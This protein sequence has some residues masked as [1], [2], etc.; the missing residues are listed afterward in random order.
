MA[1]TIPEP[2]GTCAGFVRAG[3]REFFVRVGGAGGGL[4][5]DGDLA[6]LLGEGG[7]A[8]LEARLPG[9]G[10]D[11]QVAEV[12]AAARAAAAASPAAVAPPPPPAFYA[13]LLREVGLCGW[14]AVGAVAPD[15]SGVTLRGGCGG[16]WAVEAEVLL[17]SSFPSDPPL[18]VT[19]DLPEP[20]TLPP[21]PPGGA[22]GLSGVLATLRSAARKW[23]AH[24]AALDCLDARCHVLEPER[25][26]RAHLHRRVALR[27]GAA[28]RVAL[29]K[30]DAG[31][32]P[33][34]RVT[35]PEKAARGPREA[36]SARLSAWDTGL[37]LVGN[38][39]AALG[40]ALVAAPASGGAVSEGAPR[41]CGVCYTLRLGGEL[42]SVA[43]ENEACGAP[44]HRACL[45]E[46]LHAD[47][48]AKRV[49]STLYGACPYCGAPIAVSDEAEQEV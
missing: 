29:R 36:L 48:T 17:P 34:L 19:A 40:D 6:V 7:K 8:S 32:P 3:D 39:E 1:A 31:A 37:G 35:G 44:F 49:Y 45:A 24:F 41:E 42:P 38:L 5:C 11:E 14:A 30:E 13:A 9:L 23:E 21:W 16:G 33:E 20:L 18:A 43:C 22:G 46:W 25:P 4:E 15:L 26:A 12:L 2:G 47:A 10:P 28:L 27:G